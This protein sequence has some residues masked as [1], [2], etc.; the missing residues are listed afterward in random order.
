ML[1]TLT[2]QFACS[3]LSLGVECR[4]SPA[5]FHWVV[6]GAEWAQLLCEDLSRLAPQDRAWW[7]QWLQPAFGALGSQEV[8]REKVGG[9]LDRLEDVYGE[10]C[11]AFERIQEDIHAIR[12]LLATTKGPIR[13]TTEEAHSRTTEQAR[14]DGWVGCK[15]TP[16]GVWVKTIERR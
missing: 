9:A 1:A 15:A 13:I 16:E 14:G 12:S 3:A 4:E 7:T 8:S 5:K 10:Q 6:L 2:R 11:R